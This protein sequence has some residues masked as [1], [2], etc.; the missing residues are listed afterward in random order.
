[1]LFPSVSPGL[2]DL[3]GWALSQGIAGFVRSRV[4]LSLPPAVARSERAS[5]LRPASRSP[6]LAISPERKFVSQNV[7]EAFSGFQVGAE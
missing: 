5:P 4:R 7:F 2:A 6:E 3:F 1:V